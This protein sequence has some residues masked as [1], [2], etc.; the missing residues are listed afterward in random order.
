MLTKIIN[1][2]IHKIK[3]NKKEISRDFITVLATLS[4]KFK[5]QK[6]EM[7]DRM[8]KVLQKNKLSNLKFYK[9]KKNNKKNIFST[10]NFIIKILTDFSIGKHKLLSWTISMI[11]L[12][13]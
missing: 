12:N 2:K 4:K 3:I 10:T 9:H 1:T 6:L 8:Q 13:I 11:K 5:I 7:E